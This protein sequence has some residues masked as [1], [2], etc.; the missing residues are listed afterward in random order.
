[1]PLY[2]QEQIHT[3]AAKVKDIRF[4]MF[5]SVGPGGALSSRPLTSQQI[6]GEG[7]MWFFTSDAA[8]F[9]HDLQA[10]PGANITFADPEHSIYLSL[11]GKAY[12]LKDRNKA[13]ELWNP[14]VQAWFPKGLDDPHLSLIM[15]R[16]ETA[17][18]WDANTSK[19]KQLF[20]M[21]KAAFTGERP[22]D[23]GEHTTIC[24]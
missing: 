10:H 7:N 8:E 9:T 17:E 6:D 14:A 1:M 5:T 23:L 15:L 2:H 16:I 20:A 13:K 11:T 18:Y 12:L 3:I 24:L 4:G 21:A 22:S 19:M